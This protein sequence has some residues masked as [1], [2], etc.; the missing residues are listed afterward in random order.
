MAK[1]KNLRD[2]ESL[3][4]VRRAYY[5]LGTYIDIK[6]GQLLASLEENGFCEN[7]IVV[8]CSDHGDM[9]CEKG[10]VQKRTFYEWSS[11]VPLIICFPEGWRRGRTC[12]QPVNLIDLPP[13]FL[14]MAGVKERLPMDGRSLMG[15]LDGSDTGDWEATSEFHSQGAHASC[16]MIRRE[17]FKYVC[18]HGHESQLFDLEADPGEWH[19]LA[20][21]LEYRKVEEQLKAHISEL[22]EPDAIDTAV[23]ESVRKRTLI[24]RAM[25]ITNTR[26]DVEPRFDPTKGVVDQY[27]PGMSLA[28][29]PR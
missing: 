6:V 8:F 23:R 14:D 20:G 2:P 3:R 19:N 28:D 13:T 22:F 10:M 4:R 11:R 16:F 9:L 29:I 24:K 18:I 25:E 17:E 26:W 27:L 12:T 1:A 21:K 15:L 7:T 5:A